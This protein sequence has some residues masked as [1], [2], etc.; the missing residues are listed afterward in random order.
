M[1]VTLSFIWWLLILNFIIYLVAPVFFVDKVWNIGLNRKQYKFFIL[2]QI[3]TIIAIFFISQNY[4]ELK[5]EWKISN[6]KRYAL[7]IIWLLVLS[8]FL[9]IIVSNIERKYITLPF[10]IAGQAMYPTLYDK[11]F[12]LTSNYPRNYKRNDI[13]IFRTLH[14]EKQYYI[15]RIIWLPWETIKISWWKVF[16]LDTNNNDFIELKEN[17]L[18]TVNKTYPKGKEEQIFEVPEWEYFVLW[19]NRSASADSRSCFGVCDENN[20]NYFLSEWNIVGKVWID[21]GYFNLKDFTFTHPKLKI[22]TY[23]KFLNF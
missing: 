8:I 23:P 10:Q 1:L 5:S 19:D 21:L 3:F 9:Q 15:K 17:F 13:V 6:K 22:S 20:P 18:W 7:L 16:L 11:Q 4:R 14:K 12:I 2:F